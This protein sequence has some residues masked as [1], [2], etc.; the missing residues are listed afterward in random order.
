MKDIL[1]LNI[2]DKFRQRYE[3]VQ[4]LLNTNFD[5]AFGLDISDKTIE[6]AEL[7]K[8]F[9][10]SLENHGRV[11][12]PD[13]LIKDGR[14]LDEKGLAEQIK[15]LLQHVKPRQVSTNKVILSLPESQVFSHHFVMSTPLS[16]AALRLM[17]QKEIAKILPINPTRMY[18]DIKTKTVAAGGSNG[19]G[20]LSIV[21]MGIAKDVAESYARVC[22]IVGLDVV[23]FGLEPL[24]IGRLLLAPNTTNTLII[25][26]GTRTTDV[27]VVKGND[28]L[29]LAITIPLGGTDMTKAIAQG[30][31]VDEAT[32]EAKKIAVGT[33]MS[34]ELFF[35][36]EPVVKNIAEEISRVVA[37]F[38]NSFHEKI[39]GMILV[40]GASMAGGIKE[41]IGEI[42]GKPVTS[43]S[44][45]NNF[46]SQSILGG[47]GGLVSKGGVIT[48]KGE[49]GKIIPMLYTSVIGLAMLGA[50]NE[51]ENVNLLKQ[52]PSVQINNI[53]RRELLNAGY[54]SKVAAFRIMLNSRL[55]LVIAVALCACSFL[56]FGYLWFNYETGQVY[57]IKEYKTSNVTPKAL[58]SDLSSILNTLNGGS[59]AGGAG[60]AGAMSTSS[61]TTSTG[62]K[63]AKSA[64]STISSTSVSVP[65]AK[66]SK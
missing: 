56:A 1:D 52:M 60:G 11:E 66:V 61:S 17:V 35:L 63:G 32:A 22:N 15:G 27:S 39:D 57:Q 38:E 23:A 58:S 28:E 50:S 46:E 41:K 37:Y 2:K 53:K 47:Q 31:N 24:S 6:L 21:F 18:W 9:R 29:E 48:G 12:L 54:L 65:A 36:M 14:I 25:D 5:R 34:D 19:G 49:D 26:I 13:G 20:G 3:K 10:F 4:K 16:G 40:G 64:T 7:S 55:M 45:F 44:H 8:L 59:G 51:F 43:V 62:V 33:G 30:L 42:V